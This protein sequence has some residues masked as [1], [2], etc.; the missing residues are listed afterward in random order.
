[1]PTTPASENLDL[2]NFTVGG[3]LRAGVAVRRLLRGAESL[4][5]AAD[6]IVHFFYDRCVDPESG[7][8]LDV[9]KGWPEKAESQA[10]FS[11]TPPRS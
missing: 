6:R 4:E 5:E 2:T 3:M 1:M 8:W 9:I 11:A 7:R 10:P